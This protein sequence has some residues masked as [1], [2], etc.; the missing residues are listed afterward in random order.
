M[1]FYITHDLKTPEGTKQKN[2]LLGGKF[3]IG[4]QS[5]SVHSFSLAQNT[6][7][8]DLV[9]NV[10]NFKIGKMPEFTV[11]VVTVDDNVA[12]HLAMQNVTGLYKQLVSILKEGFNLDDVLAKQDILFYSVF[13]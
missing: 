11:P 6:D 8:R 9:H 7:V 10:C 12:S 4:T 13:V 3:T 5:L 1:I 2:L